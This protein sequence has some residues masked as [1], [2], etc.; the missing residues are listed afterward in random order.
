MARNQTGKGVRVS[1][2]IVP[3]V[4]EVWQP[5]LAHSSKTPR[6]GHDRPLPQRGQR[7]PSGHRSRAKYA[8]QACS[9]PKFASNSVRFRG[10][11]STIPAYYIL[12]LPESSGYPPGLNLGAGESSVF[13]NRLL[14]LG[15]LPGLL[16]S[17]LLSVIL[18]TAVIAFGRGRLM[19][20]LNPWYALLVT[21]NLVVIFMQAQS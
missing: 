16:I 14:Q 13:I 4:T 17:K 9:V 7:K 3:A 18:V 8:R 6:T 1:W 2:K 19:R 15:Q 5:Q 10:Y 20:I 21:W 12:G 11:S